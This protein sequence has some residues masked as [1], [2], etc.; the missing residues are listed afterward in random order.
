MSK[1]H[2]PG[3]GALT[4]RYVAEVVRRIPAGRRGDVADELR[5]TIA[6][7]VDA[8]GPADA[9]A[10]E[11]EVLTEMG[12]PVRLAADYAD[13]PLALIGPGLY[14]TYVRLLA[15]LL[16]TVLPVVTVMSAALDILDGQGAGAVIGGAVGTVLSLGA[17]MIAWLTVVFALAERSGKRFAAPGR[18]WTPDDLPEPRNRKEREAQGYAGLAWHGL[19]LALIVWQHTA[20]PYRTDGGTHI[21]VLDP[22]L[23]SGWVWPVLAGLAGLAALDVIR[24]VR[25]PTRSLA[26]WSIAARVVFTLPLA[27]V[28][29][30]REFFNPAFLSDVNGDWQVPDA[31]YTVVVLL[32]LVAGVRE[33]VRRLGELR[34]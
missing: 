14:P 5:V 26:L 2:V 34:A 6:D 7:T 13:R 28:L 16:L 33:V 31:F 1:R 18:A 4:D 20:Q 32:V 10:T 24:A 9:E 23:W 27:W 8:R 12:D 25:T 30:R 22:D 29:Y 19:L 3:T 11:R 21:D 15:V 17:Q